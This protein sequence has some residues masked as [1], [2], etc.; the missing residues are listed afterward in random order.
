MTQP[1]YDVQ[2]WCGN[3]GDYEWLVDAYD[4]ND[5]LKNTLGEPFEINS[6]RLGTRAV[7]RVY[8]KF[9]LLKF[10][11][12]AGDYPRYRLIVPASELNTDH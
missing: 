10:Y 4:I 8:S 3:G 12:I 5:W 9:A 6:H 7:L 2:I 11:M 1:F